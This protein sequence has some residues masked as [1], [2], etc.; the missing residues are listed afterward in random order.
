MEKAWK[1]GFAHGQCHLVLLLLLPCPLHCTSKGPP[2]IWTEH[3]TQFNFV[4]LQLLGGLWAPF[5]WIFWTWK[6][7]IK[8]MRGQVKLHLIPIEDWSLSCSNIFWQITDLAY[9]RDSKSFSEM[10]WFRII[11]FLVISIF[12]L[13]TNG[14]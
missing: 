8:I 13:I 6:V 14:W 3:F 5:G 1:I 10:S 7:Q 9:W 12:P 11:K 4:K 2:K